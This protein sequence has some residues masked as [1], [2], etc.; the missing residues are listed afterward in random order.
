[1]TW[2]QACMAVPWQHS[3]IAFHE[4]KLD[5]AETNA[6]MYKV[7]NTDGGVNIQNLL[8][9]LPNAHLQEEG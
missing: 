2:P 3:L 5:G 9:L 6:Y 7:A 1:M 8:Q 4:C